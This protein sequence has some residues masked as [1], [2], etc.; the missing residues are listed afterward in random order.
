MKVGKGT[1]KKYSR[2]YSRTLKNGEKKTYRTEQIQITIP[3][4]EDI[5]EDREEVLIIPGSEIEEF[6]KLTSGVS[7]KP[8]GDY[9]SL[10]KSYDKIVKKYD[11]LK[12]E[13]LNTKTAYAELYEVNENLLKDYEDLRNEYNDVVD[14]FNDLAEDFDNIRY[15]KSR[16]ELLANRIKEFMLKRI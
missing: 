12:Q 15:S 5:F 13:N 14:R 6:E 11:T 16:D 4:G 2:E 7:P 8:E 10:K 9:D 3:K 1:V